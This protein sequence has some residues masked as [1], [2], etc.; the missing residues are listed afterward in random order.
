M[1]KRHVFE[2]LLNT[3]FRWPTAG[4]M[5]F[6]E[7][8]K[9]ADNAVIAEDDFTRLVLM[10]EGYKS[11]ADLAVAHAAS[12]RFDRDLLVFPILFNYRQFIELSLKYHLATHGRAVGIDANWKT[13]DLAVLWTSFRE[14]L[15][16][17]GTTDPDEADPVV[18]S[19]V[20]EFA[21]ID[22]GSYSNRYPVDR[23]GNA[24]PIAYGA[25]HLENLA[26]VMKAVAGYFTGC[27]GYLS[28]MR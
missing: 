15:E 21:K 23:Q 20:L 8:T 2:E 28:D 14:M 17:Y 22:P 18:E 6:V 27:D 19:V 9:Q 24:L 1:S 16:R 12:N 11:A 13:H 25:M 4:D 3:E 26:D 5:P 10:T 7:A